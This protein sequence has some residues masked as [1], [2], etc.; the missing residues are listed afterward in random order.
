MKRK[1]AG[2]KN[3]GSSLHPLT[4]RWSTI[5][6]LT[7]LAGV[8]TVLPAA[9]TGKIT[10]CRCQAA[11]TCG[12]D[13]CA[14]VDGDYCRNSAISY[15]IE[16][17]AINFCIGEDCISGPAAFLRP[18]EGEIWLHGSFK[19]TA[20]P[21]QSPTAMTVLLD[22]RTGIGI[23]QTSDEQGVDQVSVICDVADRK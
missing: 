22:A 10:E 20:A 23:I 15:A 17:P 8:I 16:P 19:H 7:C 2:M 5:K 6:L 1:N 3:R 11:L 14:P 13:E 12:A 21:E 9:A 18:R 4:G